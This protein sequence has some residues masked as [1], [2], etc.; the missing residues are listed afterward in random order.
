[1]SDRNA[2]W[3]AQQHRDR[4]RRRIG[5]SNAIEFFNL[6]TGPE[7]LQMTESLL[8]E[9]RERLYPPTMA[10]SMFM[11]QALHT[12]RSCQRAVDEWAA[13]R[14]AEGLSVQSVSTGAYCRARKRLPEHMIS[15]LAQRSGALLCAG[16]RAGWRWRGR[17]VKLA[18]G[19]GL[20]MPDTRANQAAYPQ[21]NSQAEGV[22]FP[23]MR[24]T[25]IICLSTG[26]VLQAAAGRY[27]GKGQ[28]ELG[29]FRS[30]YASLSAGDVLLADAL[31]C[32]Y[33]LVAALLAAGVDVLFEQ[34]GSRSTDFRRGQS[35]GRRDHRVCWTK[36]PARPDWMTPEQYAAFPEQLIVREFKAGRRVLVTS[37]LEPS[38]APKREL[39]EL[40]Q[41]RW[42]IELDFRAIKTTLGLETLSCKTPAMVHRELWV[43]LLAYNVIRLLMAQAADNAGVHPRQLSFKH[44]AQLWTAWT[45]QTLAALV[46]TQP[47]QLFKLIAQLQVGNR[48]GRIEP[49]ARKRRPKPFPWLKVP[50][51]IARQQ[52]RT[53]GHLLN[54]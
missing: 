48:P 46:A 35:L 54:A 40:Y 5:Q 15:S 22:G 3:H 50:R 43:Y 26:A 10:L 13:Q 12:D 33:F 7:L 34:H 2:H 41:R 17:C 11:R 6:L 36:P 19:T 53:H 44:T 37:L 14:A 39:A 32:N 45:S 47:A 20:S 51:V 21:P 52:I 24:L 18:D 29:L 38:C 1:M 8:P 23:Q 25:G 28:S 49:R 9:H 4:I 42:N 31:Y 30:L 16:A 27:A